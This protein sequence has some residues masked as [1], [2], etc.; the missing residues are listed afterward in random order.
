MT[1]WRKDATEFEVRVADDAKGSRFVRIPKPIYELMGRPNRV[2]FV[3]AAGG[4]VVVE[5]GDE[6]VEERSGTSAQK[7]KKKPAGKRKK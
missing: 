4:K 2:W 5:V 7:A 1:R 6:S 3:M